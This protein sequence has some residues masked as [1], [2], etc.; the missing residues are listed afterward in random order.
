MVYPGKDGLT[1]SPK[2]SA[3]RDGLEDYEYLRV[4]EERLRES[5]ATSAV[6]RSGSTRGSVRSNC[7]AA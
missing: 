3:Q 4:L 6:T 2:P 7:A 1:G 5:S